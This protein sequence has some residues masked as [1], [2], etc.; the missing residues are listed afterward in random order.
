MVME[1]GDMSPLPPH[2]SPLGFTP[3]TPSVKGFNS[4]FLRERDNVPV[5]WSNTFTLTSYSAQPETDH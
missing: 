5:T 4:R 3:M 2:P 1:E